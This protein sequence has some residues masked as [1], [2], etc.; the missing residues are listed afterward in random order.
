MASFKELMEKKGK[1]INISD[2]VVP[3][4]QM[5]H[6][7][8]LHS[9]ENNFYSQGRI[10]ELADS[11][12][13]VGMVLQPLLVR[14]TDMGEFDILSGHRR[15][16]ACI[17]NI[18]RGHKKFEMVPCIEIIANDDFIHEIIQEMIDESREIDAE[19]AMDLFC[20][21]ILIAANSTGREELTDYE[22]IMQ[23]MGLKR[24]LPLLRGDE[25]LKGRALR[26][27]IAKE[28][29]KSDGT[30]GNY[31]NI[32][33]NLV[34]EGMERLKNQ[35]LGITMA[36]K[37][38]SLNPENQRE[39]LKLE[40]ISEED[41][42]KYKS[43]RN[44]E[45]GLLDGQMYVW[46]AEEQKTS[47]TEPDEEITEDYETVTEPQSIQENVSEDDEGKSGEI[48]VPQYAEGIDEHT[49]ADNGQPVDVA[50]YSSD[51]V[52]S[53]LDVYVKKLELLVPRNNND[54][55]HRK[56]IIIKD[57]LSFYLQRIEKS[58]K[59]KAKNEERI[60]IPC[61]IGDRLYGI[62]G[63]NISCNVVEG[64]R[65]D[66]SGVYIEAGGVFIKDDNIGRYYFFSEQEAQAVYKSKI[67][68]SKAQ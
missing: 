3:K 21:Y 61:E 52:K 54:S 18:N 9:N 38:C 20:E 45:N 56:S 6:Y 37:I 15:K 58:H 1:T 35:T 5:I 40:R 19:K 26:A 44:S 65:I 67:K 43:E 49:A 66:S 62:I 29:N 27:E 59:L 14:R 25:E 63:E 12:L 42:L 41:I 50:A 46:E 4:I 32:Y 24:I 30:I 39:L 22:K 34:P 31:E 51:D 17:Y 57:A 60:H 33:N 47:G 68:R 36:S 10:E 7:S 8:K 64:Y 13:L 2:V 48:A 55:I 23:A 53:L 16:Q 28:V 11:M